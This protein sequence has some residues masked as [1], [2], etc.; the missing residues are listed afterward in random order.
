MNQMDE[1]DHAAWAELSADKNVGEQII[2][3]WKVGVERR[4]KSNFENKEN[5]KKTSDIFCGI[6]AK[7]FSKTF[8]LQRK[9]KTLAESMYMHNEYLTEYW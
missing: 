7:I 2:V 1:W 9:V 3:K 8:K 6:N 4:R 5:Q